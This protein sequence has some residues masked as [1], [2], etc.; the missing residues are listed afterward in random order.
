MKKHYFLFL[1]TF[2]CF[3]LNAQFKLGT[4]Y[5]LLIPQGEMGNNINPVHTMNLSF[6][7]TPKMFCQRFSIGTEIGFGNYAYVTKEQDLRFPDGSGIKTD[8][9]YT[10]NVVNAALGMRANL[11]AKGKAVPY[12]EAKAGT[13][14]FFS[15]VYVEDPEDQSSCKPLESKNIIRDNTFFATYGGGVQLDIA[16]FD[17]KASPGKFIIDIGINKIKGGNLNYIDT[18]NIQTHIHTDPNA[19]V[20][21][22]KGEPLNVQ[23]VNINT[24][25]IHEHQ[26]AELYNSQMRM[27]GIKIG[28]LFKLKND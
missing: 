8:V 9:I 25:T 24:E 19:P 13:I 12:V 11:T 17:K 27:I 2:I 1:A 4:N 21:P 26:V 28:M 7:Y 6:L 10:S 3:F 14:S 15:N 20:D 18:K 16:L 23:F 22:G 5:S